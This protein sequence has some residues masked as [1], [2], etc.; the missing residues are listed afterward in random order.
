LLSLLQDRENAVRLGAVLAGGRSKADARMFAA[1]L[2]NRIGGHALA[3]PIAEDLSNNR[4]IEAQGWLLPDTLA[5][6][7]TLAAMVE[8]S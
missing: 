3:R 1:Q 7:C 5:E 4:L 8:P 6:L 2:R